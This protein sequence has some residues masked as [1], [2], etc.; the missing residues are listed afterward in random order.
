MF[1]HPWTRSLADGLLDLV[2]PPICVACAGPIRA[3]DP[4]RLVCSL[5]WSRAPLIPAPRCQRC[6]DPLLIATSSCN[7]CDVL[8]P[9]V[10]CVR[11]AFLMESPVR[12][13]VHALKYRGWEAVAEPIA[14]RMA[15]VPLPQD[16]ADEVELVVPVPVSAVRLRERGYNQAALIAAELALVTRRVNVPDLLVRIRTTES[17]TALHP[18]ERRANVSGAFSIR[19]DGADRLANRHVLLIDDVW[20]TGA[21]ALACSETLLNA[22]ARAVSILTFARAVPGIHAG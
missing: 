6:W 21:T 16:V 13:I 19:T 4:V 3:D 2:F 10:R 20:T 14:R 15:R 17:Q 8:L 11:A 9:G 7:S 5:C 12:E 22:G 1:H 18:D